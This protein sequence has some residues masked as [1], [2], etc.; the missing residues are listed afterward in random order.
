M[1]MALIC[2]YLVSFCIG[3]LAF[4]TGSIEAT[5]ANIVLIFVKNLKYQKCQ[6]LGAQSG[7]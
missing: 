3:R 1:M 7:G 4:F 2:V 5:K 6:N